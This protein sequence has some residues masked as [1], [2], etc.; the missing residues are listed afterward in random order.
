MSF[1]L[2]RALNVVL[3]WDRTKFG[4]TFQIEEI[5]LETPEDRLNFADSVLS[6]YGLE[7]R[8][9]LSTFR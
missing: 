1:F 4:E 3:P 6:D 7:L 9:K 8:M 2:I 5:L